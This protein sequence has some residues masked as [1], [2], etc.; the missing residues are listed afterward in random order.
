MASPYSKDL[1]ER[2]LGAYERGMRTRQIASIFVVSPAWAR[3]VKQR[4]RETGETLPRPMGSPGVM[5]V[6]RTR[7]SELVRERPD[8]TLAELRNA[9]GVHC[10]LSTI[11]K[12]LKQLG[13][14]FKKRR[15][16]Q[17]SRI[18]PTLSREG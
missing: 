8:A 6:D 14:S 18:A 12:A 7:L 5:K 9:L 13:L 3:R 16:M 10:A 2:V 11:C 17:P 4:W 15:S 1:R